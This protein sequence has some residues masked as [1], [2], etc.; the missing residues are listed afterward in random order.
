MYKLLLL[1]T[2]YLNSIPV[3][4]RRTDRSSKECHFVPRNPICISANALIA[5]CIY[6]YTHTSPHT[7][8]YAYK[9]RLGCTI[10]E[11]E[12]RAV[13]RMGRRT[14]RESWTKRV[15]RGGGEGEIGWSAGMM[16]GEV[17]RRRSGE[18][19]EREE[20]SRRAVS[21]RLRTVSWNEFCWIN[22]FH[23]KNTLALSR[24]VSGCWFYPCLSVSAN[25]Y[26]AYMGPSPSSPSLLRLPFLFTSLFC[27]TPPASPVT[28]YLCTRRRATQLCTNR[29]VAT[30]ISR[31]VE[32]N[33]A[34]DTRR[35]VLSRTNSPSSGNHVNMD[36]RS[37]CN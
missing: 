24:G 8:T 22:K 37:F 27:L 3:L 19:E 33:L 13:V 21:W 5:L 31:W 16:R 34:A 10:R 7:C 30:S 36:T 1:H 26:T 23:Y 17:K 2:S 15:G 4:P 35:V 25:R 20:R 6:T 11:S 12:H 29:I 9:G 18:G 14:M 28:P 32:L